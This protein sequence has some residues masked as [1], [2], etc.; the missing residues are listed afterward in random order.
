MSARQLLNPQTNAPTFGF[1]SPVRLDRLMYADEPIHLLL[2]RHIGPNHGFGAAHIWAEHAQEMARFGLCSA[3]EVPVYVTMI[4]RTGTPLFFEGGSFRQTR[5][6]AVRCS[7]GTA[8]LEYRGNRDEPF[9]SI[10][11]AFSGT[12]THGTRVGTV[13]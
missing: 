2:G 9:W 3:A 12:K 1:V 7:A 5:L 8:I 11:T 4:V 13:R 10:V 6:L